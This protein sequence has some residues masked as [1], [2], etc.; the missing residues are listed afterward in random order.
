MISLYL[1]NA[2]SQY[3]LWNDGSNPQTTG[4]TGDY[5]FSVPAGTYYFTVNAKGYNSYQNSSFNVALGDEKQLNVAL[6]KTVQPSGSPVVPII[7]T[8]VI[9]AAAGYASY[10]LWLRML[11]RA[12]GPKNTMPPPSMPSAPPQ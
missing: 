9:I 4:S 6:E 3:E 5:S 7:V 10:L 12:G 8:L 1:L 2:N 11:A